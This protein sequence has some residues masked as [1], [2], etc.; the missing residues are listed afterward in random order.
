MDIEADGYLQEQLDKH[1]DEQTK[2][3]ISIKT[4]GYKIGLTKHIQRKIRTDICT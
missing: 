3:Q 2:R 1:K 4:D